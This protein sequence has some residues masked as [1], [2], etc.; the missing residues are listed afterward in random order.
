MTEKVTQAKSVAPSYKSP[1][2]VI[3]EPH[4]LLCRDQSVALPA[5]SVGGSESHDTFSSAEQATGC[6][7]SRCIN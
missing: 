7:K 6:N 1:F 3:N 5:L 4:P 2:S